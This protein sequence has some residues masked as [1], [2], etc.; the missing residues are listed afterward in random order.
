MPIE[1]GLAG[2]MCTAAG[3]VPS[4]SIVDAFRRNRAPSWWLA[5]GDWRMRPAFVAYVDNLAA[6]ESS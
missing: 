6:E 1:P 2:D 3:A 5:A 4:R